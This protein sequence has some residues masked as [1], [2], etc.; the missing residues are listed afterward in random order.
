M[1]TVAGFAALGLLLLLAQ[2]AASWFPDV[3]RPDPLLVFALVMGLRGS[4]LSSLV[5]AF[6]AGVA[7][8]VQ[9]GSPL[10][11]YA[12]LRVTACVVT[13]AFDGALY[14]R[15]PAPWAIFVAGYALVDVVLMALCLHWFVGETGL[16]WSALLVRTPGSALATALVSAPVLWAFRRLDV[17]SGRDPGW[18]VLA[19][20]TRARP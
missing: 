16:G 20:G 4:S 14:L 2:A 12:L 15:A 11:L 5:L 7:V 17:E 10:G 3:F 6:G 9:S 8:D 1:K 19:S 18:G 13:R